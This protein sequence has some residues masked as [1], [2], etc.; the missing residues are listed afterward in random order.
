MTYT[1]YVIP[2]LVGAIILIWLALYVRRFKE[3]PTAQIFSLM[4]AMMALR[5]LNQALEYSA[6]SL[7]WAIPVVQLRPILNQIFT[8]VELAMVL[9]YTGRAAWLNRRRLGL[10]LI[11][12]VATTILSLTSNFHKFFRYDYHLDL[13]GPFPI[14]LR[15]NGAGF[16]L[17]M[18]YNFVLLFIALG[19]LLAA[20]RDPKLNKRNTLFLF[21][22]LAIPMATELLYNL[23]PTP[24]RSYNLTPTAFIL[25][26]ILYIWAMLR[27]KL[28]S[29]APVARSIVMENIADLVIVLSPTDQIEDFNLAAQSA[30]AL[31]SS[32]IGKCTDSLPPLWAD[33]FQRFHQILDYKGEVSLGTGTEARIYDLSISAIRDEHKRLAGRLFL[34][35][36]LTER[37]QAEEKLRLSEERFRMLAENAP[38]AISVTDLET[39]DVLYSNQRAVN[40]FN[41]PMD[42]LI[43]S[44]PRTRYDEKNENTSF[45]NLMRSEHQVTDLEKYMGNFSG[46]ELWV[47]INANMS[48]YGGRAAI[49]STFIDISERKQAEAALAHEQN[50]LRTLINILPDAIYAMDINK[51]KTLTNPADLAYMGLKDEAQALG[52]TA[53]EIYDTELAADFMAVDD[54]VL[55]NDQPVINTEEGLIDSSGKQRWFL[56]SKMPL[57]NE[58]GDVIGLVGIGHDITERKQAEEELR[59][60]NSELA[61]QTELAKEMA[62]KAEKATLAKSSFLANMSHEIRTPMNGVIGITGL[63]LDTNLDN[64]QQ[65]YA[66]M[67]RS[68]GESLLELINDILD[69]SKIEAGKLEIETLDFDLRRLLD[70]FAAMMVIRTRQKGLELLCAAEPDVPSLLQGD[71]GRLRQILTNL[72]GNAIKFT[73]HGEV[74]VRVTKLKE[75][76]EEVTLRFAVRD[77]GI[78]IPPAKLGLLFNKF[79]QV[80]SSTTR[81]YGGTGLGLAISKQLAE[82]MGGEIGV[83]SEEG[84]GSE[85]WFTVCLK[86]LNERRA[87]TPRKTDTEIT[88]LAFDSKKRILLVEDNLINQKVA[89]GILKKLGLP[90]DAA[91]NGLEALRAL[92]SQPYDLVLM[93]MHMPQMDGLEATQHIRAP[94]SKV[95]DHEIPIIAMTASAMQEDRQR[96]L[97][98]GMNDFITKPVQSQVLAQVLARWL[99][100]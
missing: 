37:K 48:H 92:E 40:L 11:V 50:L 19:I 59:R 95:L 58:D 2:A 96:C 78:G 65:R 80:D 10:L 31:S 82:L 16:W 25:S 60:I 75:T 55:K 61:L 81:N 79:T 34:L 74:S 68:S 43:G 20:L 18:A 5:N 30:C 62:E 24:M 87:I 71:P 17:Y 88:A 3:V 1:P 6:T 9:A 90:A 42:E 83:E 97:Q 23:G 77:T 63:L 100:E 53:A 29:V 13:S 35:H 45:I 93:D 36:D 15:T 54:L 84:K 66:E 76:Q 67:I 46:R 98:A 7:N 38:L 28:F 27:N 44:N 33:F 56:S 70:D 89:L 32:S 14:L 8:F 57:H 72:L 99:P 49:Q 94:Q 4:T 22:A 12:P 85:F 39:G 47:S 41:M 26:A 21:F 69:F 91:G 51:R 73:E 64:E 52:K 86:V